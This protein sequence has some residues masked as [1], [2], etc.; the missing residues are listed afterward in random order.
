MFQKTRKRVEEEENCPVPP[1]LCL[2]VSLPAAWSL[3]RLLGLGRSGWGWGK[4]EVGGGGGG[5]S[6]SHGQVTFQSSKIA[7]GRREREREKEG[8]RAAI[9]RP[10]V[11]YLD[12]GLGILFCEFY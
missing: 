6:F 7:G 1:S 4:A 10:N 5:N 3:A 12:L 11:Q 2:P 9:I 8:G